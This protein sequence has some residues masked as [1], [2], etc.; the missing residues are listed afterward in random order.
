[1][2]RAILCSVLVGLVGCRPDPGVPD[3][4]GLS[5]LFGDGGTP[6][7]KPGPSPS[8]PAPGGSSSASST[9]AG[10]RTWL[11]IDNYFIFSNSYATAPDEDCVEGLQ[12]DAFDFNGT[13]FW[14]G[15][16]FYN[17]PTNLTGWTTLHVSLKSED[18]G[19]ARVACGCCTSARRPPRRRSPWR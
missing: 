14:G 16:L 3:Y 17:A 18:P 19:L 15:G 1:M 7:P 5:G 9:K 6:T 10:I 13:G 8:S 4:S 11:P 2:R 12:S